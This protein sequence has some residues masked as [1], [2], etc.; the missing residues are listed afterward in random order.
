VTTDLPT[1]FPAPTAILSL[2]FLRAGEL[3]V[4][5]IELHAR[6]LH[7]SYQQHFVHVTV[8]RSKNNIKKY[9]SREKN[10]RCVIKVCLKEN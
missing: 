10:E 3:E 5:G 8:L 7:S 4:H 2:I 6:F 1:S 9:L